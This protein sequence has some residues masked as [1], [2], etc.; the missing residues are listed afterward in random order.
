[1]SIEGRVLSISKPWVRPI[2]RGK[3]RGMFEFGAKLSI[4]LVDG[5]AEVHR[6]CREPYNECKDLK[7]QIKAY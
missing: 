5:M 6:L 2:T 7:G 1:M 4:R 3:A